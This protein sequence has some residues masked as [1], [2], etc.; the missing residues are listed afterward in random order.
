MSDFLQTTV[1]WWAVFW[2]M[3]TFWTRIFVETQLF[4]AM[5]AVA[6]ILA[7][8][9]HLMDAHDWWRWDE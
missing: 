6:S 8:V 7:L 9:F 5:G 3:Y 2:I 1:T 4:F